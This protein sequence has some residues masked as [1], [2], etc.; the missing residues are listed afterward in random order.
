MKFAFFFLMLSVAAL[1]NPITLDGREVNLP[2]TI[3][4]GRTMVELRT[5]VEELGWH[6]DYQNG[7]AV[8]TTGS[9]TV[10]PTVTPPQPIPKE[11]TLAPK[12]GSVSYNLRPEISARFTALLNDKQ[13]FRLTVNG[14]DV[15]SESVL[16]ANEIRW[17]PSRQ[18][19]GGF[20]KI[21]L[22]ATGI[23]GK[24][25]SREW[26]FRLVNRLTD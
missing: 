15:S 4:N 14:K 7:R 18:L 16:Q 12:D 3:Q 10:K 17:R 8:I 19:G 5:L 9:R 23:D 13:P 24:K 22:E 25:I 1:A 21:T 26:S 2:T 6:L 20:H 11:E